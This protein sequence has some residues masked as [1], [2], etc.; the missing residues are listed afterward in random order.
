MTARGPPIASALAHQWPSYAAYALMLSNAVVLPVDDWTVPARVPAL[1]AH[2]LVAAALAASAAAVLALLAMARRIEPRRTGDPV[3]AMALGLVWF[4]AGTAPFV[5][6]ADRLFLRYAYFGSA[7]LSLLV[8]AI[9]PA[10][11]EWWRLRQ[12]RTATA[13]GATSPTSAPARP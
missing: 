13:A 11:A 7:G 10:A 8:L 5:V 12:A 9:P 3:R 2:P 4:L 1:A 6:F